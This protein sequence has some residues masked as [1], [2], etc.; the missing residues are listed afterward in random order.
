[1]FIRAVHEF[2]GGDEF[3]DG[4]GQCLN[5]IDEFLRGLIGGQIV[6]GLFLEARYPAVLFNVRVRSFLR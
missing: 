2:F 3:H 5:G 1:M 6:D 4:A